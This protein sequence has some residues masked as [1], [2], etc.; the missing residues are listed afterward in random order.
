[1][2]RSIL[3]IC[4][5]M[6]GIVLAGCQSAPEPTAL[7][8]ETLFPT[9]TPFP[10]ETI[11]LTNTAPPES[12][13]TQTPAPTQTP[14]PE[15]TATPEPTAAPTASLEETYGIPDGWQLILAE[16]PEGEIDFWTTTLDGLYYALSP[17]WTCHDTPDDAGSTY[18]CILDESA[19]RFEN[20]LKTRLIVDS[21]WWDGA[22]VLTEF[23]PD[24]EENMAYYGYTCESAFLKIDGLDAATVACINPEYDDTIDYKTDRDAYGKANGSQLPTFFIYILN[25]DRIEQ[26]H[27]RTW[28]NS[29]M[30]LLFEGLVPHIHYTNE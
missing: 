22:T 9:E 21:Y 3:F 26:F 7:P 27:F 15:P 2:I 23:V 18:T 12:T 28:E 17:E 14:E 6:I 13:A 24:V 29:Q 19:D 5:L 16:P 20:Q 30:P 11:Q 10:T 1:M 4:C 25:G 8:T